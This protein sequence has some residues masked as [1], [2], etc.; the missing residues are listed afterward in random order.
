VAF[1]AAIDAAHVGSGRCS[2]AVAAALAATFATTVAAALAT[3]FATGSLTLITS[4][5]RVD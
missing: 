1:T 5:L 3:T 4:L 2:T